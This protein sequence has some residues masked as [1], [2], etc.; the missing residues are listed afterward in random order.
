[1]KYVQN[2]K[3][4]SNR[5]EL[6]KYNLLKNNPNIPK[7]MQPPQT[8]RRE[9]PRPKV[10]TN[11]AVVA[12][13]FLVYM[14]S[15][16]KQFSLR[17]STLKENNAKT[18]NWNLRLKKSLEEVRTQSISQSTNRSPSLSLIFNQGSKKDKYVAKPVQKSPKSPTK[19]LIQSSTSHS[20]KS[21]PIV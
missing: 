17:P 5:S 6:G 9:S 16:E 11:K 8:E 12:R 1:M 15:V 3:L 2:V 7:F 20:K 14:K 10:L 4:P 19:I 18:L 21:N 13:N